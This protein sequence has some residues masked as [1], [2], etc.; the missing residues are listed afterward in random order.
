LNRLK[1]GRLFTFRVEQGLHDNLI[2]WL[3]EDEFGRFWFS[4]NRG[5]FRINRAELNEVADLRPGDYRFELR[6]ANAHGVWSETP[7]L[8]A[9]SLAAYFWQT[10]P[11][12]GVC[13]IALTGLVAG[14][15]TYRL[16]WQHRWWSARH[17]QAPAEERARIARD[18]H[19]D[20]GTALTGVA[21]EIEVA[22]RQSDH[23]SPSACVR[24]WPTCR[25]TPVP[26]RSSSPF[27]SL[28]PN[29]SS[30][31]GTTAGA[32]TR[33]ASGPGPVTD[34][35]TC[36]HASITSAAPWPSIH[37]RPPAR[38]SSSACHWKAHRLEPHEHSRGHCRRRHLGAEQPRQIH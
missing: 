28:M 21:L 31:C 24:R 19:D 6:A 17:A 1:D 33:P 15:T 32:S 13:A 3:E 20:L 7:A 10:W 18:L 34:C 5:I 29:W 26:P 16:R 38:A 12:Y 14:I 25:G 22:R 4:G 30:R 2:N 23:N 9:F 36:A 11:F 27:P 37:D 35:T 8:V